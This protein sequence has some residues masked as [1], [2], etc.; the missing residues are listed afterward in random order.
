[1]YCT[2]PKQLHY[3]EFAERMEFL[4]YNKEVEVT[5][6]D[7][8]EVYAE[9][10]AKEAAHQ[11]SVEVA[12]RCLKKGYSMEDASELSELPL[13]EVRALAQKQSS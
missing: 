7:P 6:V 2:D 9:K 8:I 13:E 4:K 3:K 10:R 11:K 12:L 1:M 5:M